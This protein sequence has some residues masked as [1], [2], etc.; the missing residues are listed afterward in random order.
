MPFLQNNQKTLTLSMVVGALLGAALLLSGGTSVK[1]GYV[2]QGHDMTTVK[3]AV[4]DVG[5]EVTHELGIINAVGAQLDAR[6]LALL[7]EQDSV[8][9]V[10]GNGPIEVAGKPDKGSGGSD[11]GGGGNGVLVLETHYPT[12]VNANA[13]HGMGLDGA[14]IGIAVLDTG[15]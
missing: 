7:K 2:I 5:G 11:S 9:G 15:L 4:P 10:Y 3:A 8:R 13:V 6:Q 14:G 12:L 1:E